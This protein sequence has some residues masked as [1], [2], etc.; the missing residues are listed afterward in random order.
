MSHAYRR[1]L[2]RDIGYVWLAPELVAEASFLEWARAGELRQP[3]F[4][5]IRYDKDARRS[6]PSNECGNSIL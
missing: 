1:N 6:L 4:Q 2:E 3:T 5:G